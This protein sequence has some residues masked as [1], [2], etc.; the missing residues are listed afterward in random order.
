MGI[1]KRESF[2]FIDVGS[3]CKID[4]DKRRSSLSGMVVFELFFIES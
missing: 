3:R 2:G 4:F 1:S